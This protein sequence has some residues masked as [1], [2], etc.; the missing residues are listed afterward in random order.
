KDAF[1][2]RPL[3][4][5]QG[6]AAIAAYE[7]ELNHSMLEG[8]GS[9]PGLQVRGITSPHSLDRRVPTFSF[10]LEGWEPQAIAEALDKE[11]IN[12]WNGN[13]YALAVTERL[14]LEDKGGLLRVGLAHYNTQEEIDRLVAT[15]L[16]A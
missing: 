13:F 9:I 6:M 10:T 5:K 14:G 1:S 2:G 15:I 16:T 12:V 7:L 4:L 3:A 8:L 11:G